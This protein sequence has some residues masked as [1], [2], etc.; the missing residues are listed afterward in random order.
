MR[1]EGE[2]GRRRGERRAERRHWHFYLWREICTS[3]VYVH[4]Y[5]E[6]EEEE[7]GGKETVEKRRRD[8]GERKVVDAEL[9][10]LG[11]AE[12]ERRI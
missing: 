6:E 2:G 1:E 4:H 8:E 3:V 12:E 7:K 10:F 9:R 11:T 5:K